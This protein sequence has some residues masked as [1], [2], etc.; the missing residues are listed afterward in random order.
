MR[1][2]ETVPLCSF[3]KP[4]KLSGL[5]RPNRNIFSVVGWVSSWISVLLEI[6]LSGKSLSKKKYIYLHLSRKLNTTQNR[7]YMNK[8]F[9]KD[10]WSKSIINQTRNV[11]NYF[12][13]E[14]NSRLGITWE[15]SCWYTVKC[16]LL[17]CGR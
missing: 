13:P 14:N 4:H 9:L 6:F 1:D 8:R 16:S 15:I 11:S 2:I 10:Y 5:Y 7:I 17:I 3:L 12:W